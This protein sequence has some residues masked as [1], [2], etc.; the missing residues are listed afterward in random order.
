M[1][2][3]NIT[4]IGSVASGFTTESYS[5]VRSNPETQEVEVQKTERMPEEN[6]GNNIDVTA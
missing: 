4:G 5:P 2:I 3:A 6:K 1:E